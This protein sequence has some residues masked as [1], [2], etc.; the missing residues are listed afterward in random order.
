MNWGLFGGTFDPV[1]FGHLRAA[2]ELAAVL[3]LGRV[4][5]IPAAT[6]PHKTSRVITP[7]DHR[8]LMTRLAVA[9][10]DRFSV[11]DIEGHR[12]GKSFS[13]ETVRYFLNAQNESL[14][15]Y[16]LTGQDA[17]DAITTW[18]DWEALLGLCHF[19]VMTRP[20]Y[21]NE[22]L[23]KILPADMAA[24]YVYDDRQDCFINPQGKGIY[25]RKTTFLDISS[26]DIRQSIQSGRSVRYLTPD[27][28][29]RY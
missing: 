14:N 24:K 20:G 21:Q 6:P 10:N 7:F 18:R 25:F 26:S 27:A 11:S 23:E 19:A 9:G 28:V 12:E 8:L 2:S 22:G 29:I 1:H 5:F 15:L 3:N 13:I 16:F 4:I 17:F